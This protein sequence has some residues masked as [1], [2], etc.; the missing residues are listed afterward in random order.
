MD[1]R[2]R[3]LRHL[4]R[5]IQALPCDLFVRLAI[6]VFRIARLARRFFARA[7]DALRRIPLRAT[8]EAVVGRGRPRDR[9]MD[10]QS[11]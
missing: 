1:Q 5:V 9:P 7:A 4:A 11:L 6:L 2:K 3:F 10:L 8:L